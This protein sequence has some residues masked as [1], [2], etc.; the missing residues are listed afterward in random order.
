[1]N[2]RSLRLAALAAFG[3]VTIVAGA[4]ACDDQPT[5]AGRPALARAGDAPGTHIQY[6]T[7]V[8][9]GDGLARTYA[10]LDARGGNAPTEVGVALDER[11]L[12]GLP[13]P[14]GGEHAGHGDMHEYILPLPA[15]HGTPFQFVELDWNA[16]GHEP[17]G[18]YTT[19]HFD[20]HFYTISKAERDAIVKT[21]P[22]YAA[23]GNNLPAADLIPPFWIV[24]VPPGVPPV[25]AA[26]ERMGLHLV[27]VRSPELQGMLGNPAGYRPFTKTFIHGAWDGRITFFEPM[28]T[29]DYIVAK[30]DAADEAVR[31]EITP[32]PTPARYGA[33][34]YYP[35]AYRITWDAERKEYRIALSGLTKR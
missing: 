7:P 13:A 23:K 4:A 32:L 11:A 9:L 34:G 28:I 26:I 24:P 15:Q 20:F 30:K 1:M 19:P 3:T 10:V 17:D 29:R 18:I 31:D 25:I 6:G 35:T 8:K 2:A 27:D 21:D 14:A 5:A 33:P 22:Q 16:A 12:D